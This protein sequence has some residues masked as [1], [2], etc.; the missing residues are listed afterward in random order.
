MFFLRKHVVHHYFAHYGTE[1]HSYYNKKPFIKHCNNT[2]TV[3]MYK[4]K[5]KDIKLA[6]QITN[7]SNENAIC[8]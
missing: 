3:H 7:V 4:I 8:Y 5:L 6:Y 1:L 2:N